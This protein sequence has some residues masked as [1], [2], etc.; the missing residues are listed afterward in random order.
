MELIEIKRIL[1]KWNDVHVLPVN[2]SP[3][4]RTVTYPAGTIKYIYDPDTDLIRL[5]GLSYQNLEFTGSLE[6]LLKEYEIW[7]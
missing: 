7:S 6:I 2:M 3:I 1:N 4:G 5:N